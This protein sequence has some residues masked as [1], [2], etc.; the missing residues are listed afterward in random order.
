MID[1]EQYRKYK[2]FVSLL[3]MLQED[4]NKKQQSLILSIVGEYDLMLNNLIKSDLNKKS[5]LYFLNLTKLEFKNNRSIYVNEKY[6][7][8]FKNY[9]TAKWRNKFKLIKG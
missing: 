1:I 4:E 5:K 9:I 3:N 2:C 7:T 6:R 8:Y